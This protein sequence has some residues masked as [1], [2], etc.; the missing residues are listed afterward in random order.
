ME[1]S[2]SSNTSCSVRNVAV[3]V[4]AET[5]SQF[6]RQP[7]LIHS[8]NLVE[9][10]QTLPAAMID[11]D[12]KRRLATRRGHRCDEYCAQMIVHFGW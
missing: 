8:A 4:F 12:P 3:S 1:E 5:N 7:G 11:A 10:D 6:F 2:H 9:Q